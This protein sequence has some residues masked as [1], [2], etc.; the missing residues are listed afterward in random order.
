MERFKMSSLAERKDTS[1][2]N[3]N[4]IIMPIYSSVCQAVWALIG[5][6]QK[7]GTG[8]LLLDRGSG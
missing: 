7:F 5:M 1:D 2:Q 8:A 4:Y 3:L 6:F